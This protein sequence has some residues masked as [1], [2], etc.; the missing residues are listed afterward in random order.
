MPFF[1]HFLLRLP[2]ITTPIM[3]YA[4]C[5]TPHKRQCLRDPYA[6]SYRLCLAC[7]CTTIPRIPTIRKTTVLRSLASPSPARPL[8]H[9]HNLRTRSYP[10]PGGCISDPLRLPFSVQPALR[11]GPRSVES[12]ARATRHVVR[13]YIYYLSVTVVY[14]S[15]HRK[16]MDACPCQFICHSS[17]SVGIASTSRL[18]AVSASSP[19][20]GLFGVTTTSAT[21]L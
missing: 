20:I 19:C 6:K 1:M 14:I 4:V 9:P 11:L 17:S 12:E 10:R 13:V 3:H 16:G 7:G 18:R 2:C 5:I 8:H 21:S 15:A